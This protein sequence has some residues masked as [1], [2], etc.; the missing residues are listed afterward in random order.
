VEGGRAWIGPGTHEVLLRAR[1][2]P[3]ALRVR[4]EG[5]GVLRAPGGPALPIPPAGLELDLRPEPVAALAGRR[6]LAE[7]L[8]R[9]RLTLEGTAEVALRLGPVPVVR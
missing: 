7:T 8:S 6:G 5:P 2:R 9:L 4:V 1:E 3:E